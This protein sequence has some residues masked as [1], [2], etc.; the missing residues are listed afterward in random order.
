MGKHRENNDRERE[1]KREEGRERKWETERRRSI[2]WEIMIER[3]KESVR[4][5]K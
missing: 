4:E 2:K 3:E 1:C 5:R